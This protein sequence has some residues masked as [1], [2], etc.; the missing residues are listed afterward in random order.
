MAKTLRHCLI[1]LGL[2][3]IIGGC[4]THEGPR[5]GVRPA[6][7]GS[8]AETQLAEDVAAQD[9]AVYIDLIRSM[10]KQEQY[11]AALAHVQQRRASGARD[12]DELRFFEAEAR[13]GLGQVAQAHEL[14]QSLFKTALAGQ[15]YHGMGLLYGR[16][17]PLR[18]LDYLKQA[19]QRLPADAQIRNDY[20][21]ALMRS[22]RM[23]EAMMELSTAVELAPD[24]DIARNNLLLLM[25]VQRNEAAVQRIISQ[26]AVPAETV[27]RLRRQALT[28]QA[29]QMERGGVR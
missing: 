10:L 23:A 15:A 7:V 6:G 4:A 16:S 12:N 22:G 14:Y 26:A 17:N 19:A 1:S 13:R 20:G 2:A 3:A 9:R 11:Y 28:M 21:Y 29:P 8:S 24:L 5:A 25:M 27:S 18:A